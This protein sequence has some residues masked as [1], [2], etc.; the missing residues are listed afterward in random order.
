MKYG[1]RRSRRLSAKVMPIR[2]WR[3]RTFH[4]ALIYLMEYAEALRGAP[5]TSSDGDPQTVDAPAIKA[6]GMDL[7]LT[8]AAR[9]SPHSQGK[10]NLFVINQVTE[11]DPRR[12]SLTSSF[13][14]GAFPLY[15]LT[16]SRY[17][18]RQMNVSETY[19]TDQLSVAGLAVLSN[20]ITLRSVKGTRYRSDQEVALGTTHILAIPIGGDFVSLA[21]DDIAVISVDLA[22]PP[23]ARMLW[24]LEWWYPRRRFCAR[25]QRLQNTARDFIRLAT[26]KVAQ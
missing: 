19:P 12:I 16:D 9:I 17:T 26:A 18:Y 23:L 22:L 13:F 24:A 10:A 21:E 1:R 8:A 11:A 14:V 5:P 6:W 2:C 7:V 3:E 15:Q 25:A 20:R 4:Q